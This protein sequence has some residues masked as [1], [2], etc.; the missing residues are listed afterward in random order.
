MK[1]LFAWILIGTFLLNTSKG[2]FA[3]AMTTETDNS[4]LFDIEQEYEIVATVEMSLENQTKK[5]QYFEEQGEIIGPGAFWVDDDERIHIL[6]A[7]SRKILSIKGN[8]IREFN[9]QNCY[10][11]QDIICYDNLYYIYDIN[12]CDAL[13]I[14]DDEGNFL[15]KHNIPLDTGEYVKKIFIN[16]GKI[17]VTTFFDNDYYLNADGEW[18]MQKSNEPEVHSND[19]RKKYDYIRYFAVDNVGYIYTVNTKIVQDVSILAGEV[20]ISKISSAGELLGEYIINASDFLYFPN[21]YIQVTEDGNVYIMVPREDY[22][23]IRKVNMLKTSK[24]NFSE[25]NALAHQKEQEIENE[26]IAVISISESISL[27]REEVLDRANRIALY[28]WYLTNENVDVSGLTNVELPE[29]I[30]KIAEENAGKT[31]WKVQMQGIP[32]CWGGF[33]SQYSDI[34]KINLTFAD[35]IASGYVAGNVNTNGYYKQKTAGLDCSGYVCAAY[36]LTEKMGTSDLLQYGT[37]VNSLEEMQTMDFFVK[38]G[39]TLLFYQMLDDSY[40]LVCEC[41]TDSQKTVVWQRTVDW[42]FIKNNYQMRTPW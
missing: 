40:V 14:Y 20:S 41:A 23:E 21:N 3:M 38:N 34:T 11:P 12:T 25:I 4:G 28:K 24:S 31:S 29:Y 39:H 17:T 18:K 15:I 35:A 1:K 37:K 9:I 2:S 7:R 30:A 26:E 22:V 32:Y 27:T 19:L 10:L 36:G 8:E 13:Y 42:L 5:V 16:D 6:D 33:Y